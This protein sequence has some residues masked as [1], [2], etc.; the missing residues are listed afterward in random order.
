MSAVGHDIAGGLDREPMAEIIER[1]WASA[2]F[3]PD[4]RVKTMRGSLPGRMLRLLED[5][6]FVWQ[7]HDSTAELVAMPGSLDRGSK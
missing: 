5:G 2:E 7:P 4:D 6:W 1:L 3:Q